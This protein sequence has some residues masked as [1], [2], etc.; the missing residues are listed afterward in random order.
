MLHPTFYLF[1]YLAISIIKLHYTVRIPLANFIQTDL[2]SC[3]QWKCTNQY[4]LH[5]YFS[6]VYFQTG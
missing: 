2:S 1:I 4:V 6:L 5:I 3:F